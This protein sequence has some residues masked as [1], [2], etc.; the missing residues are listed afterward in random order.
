MS[1]PPFASLTGPEPFASLQ[2]RTLSYSLK[3]EYRIKIRATSTVD[4]LKTNS[5]VI[6][7]VKL[8]CQLISINSP[9]GVTTIEHFLNFDGTY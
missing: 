3:G 4:P 6:I 2:I 8:F 5:E 7:T 9:N 1:L